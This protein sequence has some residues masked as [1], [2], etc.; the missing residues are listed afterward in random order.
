M[1]TGPRTAR[2]AERTAVRFHLEFCSTTQRTEMEFLV[3]LANALES[4]ML[5]PLGVPVLGRMR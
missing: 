1:E 5:S 4:L 3:P 2:V